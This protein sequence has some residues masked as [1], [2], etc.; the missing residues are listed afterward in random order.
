M[1]RS[2]TQQYWEIEMAEYILLIH[3]D[4]IS[5]DDDWGPYIQK[6]QQGGFFEG[7][8][9]I[10]GGVCARK[11][12][13]PRSVTGHLTGYIRVNA[14]SIVKA[15]SLLTGNPHFEA[16]GTVEIRELPRTD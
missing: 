12:G 10:G 8:S 2:Q 9:A 11:S 16:S 6:L 15:K 14:D 13:E 3:D 1:L 4:A 5:N 7:G